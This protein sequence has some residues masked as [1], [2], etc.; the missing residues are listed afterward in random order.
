MTSITRKDELAP[1]SARAPGGSAS[2]RAQPTPTTSKAG[3]APGS[4]PTAE[5]DLMRQPQPTARALLPKLPMPTV[6]ARGADA[7]PPPGSSGGAHPPTAR[8]PTYPPPLQ[9]LSG[10]YGLK[11]GTSLSHDL[12]SVDPK[13]RLRGLKA[14][15]K[16]PGNWDPYIEMVAGDE[17][18]KVRKEL[19]GVMLRHEKQVSPSLVQR[20]L[21]AELSTDTPPD[22]RFLA[23]GLLCFV[24][25]VDVGP[26]LVR[27]A[28]DADEKVRRSVVQTVAYRLEDLALQDVHSVLMAQVTSGQPAHR[29][30]ALELIAKKRAMPLSPYL[31]MCAGDG[32]VKLRRA[33]YR[34]LADADRFL[35][36]S[37]DDAQTIFRAELKA[38][39]A[40]RRLEAIKIMK[41]LPRF[42]ARALLEA[43]MSDATSDDKV[44]RAAKK[45]LSGLA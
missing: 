32:D 36:L 13:I 27:S 3:P 24:K 12:Q 4:Q 17:H 7:P 23:L 29:L 8:A 41:G 22:R 38:P 2:P 6:G 9:R 21:T 44:R 30:L 19:L 15:E 5:Q 25:S 42:D 31:A 1:Q 11:P 43:C 37:A 20:M 10:S 14:L 39:E 40:G 33:I 45:A 26:F 16:A 35:S 28:D 34:T 18:P